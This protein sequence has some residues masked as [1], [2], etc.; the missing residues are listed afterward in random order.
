MALSREYWKIRRIQ[1]IENVFPHSLL[2]RTPKYTT[3]Y[4][5]SFHCLYHYPYNPNIFPYCLL[6]PS[7]L[8]SIFSPVQ[9]GARAPKTFLKTEQAETE[10]LKGVRV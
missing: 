4:S 6:S 9:S 5:S 1:S 8:D 7:K 3:L 10:E 2:I